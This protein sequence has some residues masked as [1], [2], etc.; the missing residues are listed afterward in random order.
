MTRKKSQV[1]ILYRPIPL[2]TRGY[3][4]FHCPKK[5]LVL[6]SFGAYVK[7]S[8]KFPAPAAPRRHRPS[9]FS[10]QVFPCLTDDATTWSTTR[11]NDRW[12]PKT[13]RESPA[14]QAIVAAGRRKTDLTI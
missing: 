8:V 7:F 1:R 13:Q 11:Q 9:P 6:S 3:S 10:R 4:S 12:T 14:L 2:I 5:P